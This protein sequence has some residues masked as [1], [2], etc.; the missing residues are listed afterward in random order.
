MTEER[1]RRDRSSPRRP[2]QRH[3]RRTADGPAGLR[4]RHGRRSRT[5]RRTRRSRRTAGHLLDLHR[6]GAGPGAGNLVGSTRNNADQALR[7]APGLKPDFQTRSTATSRK[8][9]VLDVEKDGDQ[10]DPGTTITRQDLEGQPGHRCRTWSAARRRPRPGILQQRRLQRQHR[11]RAAGPARPGTVVEPEPGRPTRR[12]TGSNVTDR[13]D[14]A[15]TR[16]R[17]RPTPASPTP[18]APTTPP[19]GT[20]AARSGSWRS[21]DVPAGRLRRCEGGPAAGLDLGGEFRGAS[22]A[23]RAGRRRPASSPAWCGRPRSAPTRG[24]TARPRSAARGAASP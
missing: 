1:G 21:A 7:G 18:A 19:G 24:G 14:R 20:A 6:P 13:R 2:D 16:T 9:Q 15:T 23:P 22:R 3:G 11:D 12:S 10:V 4:H 8:D 17:T 5:R